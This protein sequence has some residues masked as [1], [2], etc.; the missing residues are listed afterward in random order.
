MHTRVNFHETSPK[1]M[2]TLIGVE[3][4]LETCSLDPKILGLIKLRASQINGCAFCVNMHYEEL[5][6]IE[7]SGAFLNLVPVWREAPCFT[8]KERAALAWTESVTL[9]ADTHV[10]DHDYDLVREHFTDE[11]L[12][13]LTVAI[14]QI[15]LWNRLAVSF[16]TKPAIKSAAEVEADH[17]PS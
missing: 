11:E 17:D 10:P 13:N 12:V 8:D 6:K 5:K 1:A 7:I 3:T 9:L 14:G 15:N 4:Y 2:K 16:R